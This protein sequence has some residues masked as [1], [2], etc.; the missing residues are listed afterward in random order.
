MSELNELRSALT[1]LGQWA[2]TSAQVIAVACAFTIITVFHIVLG[3]LV[4]KSLALQRPEPTALL[5]V[6]P[7][8]VFLTLF[9]PGIAFLNALGNGIMRMLGLERGSEEGR[10][11][12][13][14]ELKLLVAASRNAGL[15]DQSQQDVVE[16]AF[17]MGNRR[18]RSIMTPRHD[19]DWVDADGSV[20]D[21]LHGIRHGRHEQIV[22]ARGT[23]D[24]VVG[25][26]RKQD[27]LD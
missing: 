14:E 20:E 13:T 1:T 2:V 22:V 15:V 27:L 16:R 11:H 17:A 8:R 25:I 10:L 19:V 9:W 12:S 21:I 5:I 7:L 3:E 26:L 6:R 23:L 18:V 4:P 24:D